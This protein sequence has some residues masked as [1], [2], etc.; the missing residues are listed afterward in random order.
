MNNVTI[1]SQEQ[2]DVITS[3]LA[4]LIQ[5]IEFLNNSNTN[6]Y[7]ELRRNINQDIINLF[8][9]MR[10]KEQ[11]RQENFE[12]EDNLI[13]LKKVKSN[14]EQC[15]NVQFWKILAAIFISNMVVVPLTII[16]TKYAIAIG[17]I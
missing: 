7:D 6:D 12:L 5:K 4:E 15:S 3:D 16:V 1:L 11:L 14:F 9:E 2:A 13:E 8:N 17:L 10:I